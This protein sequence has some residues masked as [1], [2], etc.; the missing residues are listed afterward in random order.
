M[1]CVT[2]KK[3]GSKGSVFII[4]FTWH[5]GRGKTIGTDNKSVVAKIWVCGEDLTVKGHE[6]TWEWKNYSISWFHGKGED[7]ESV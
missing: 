6:E 2:W 4:S 5:S 3:S 7:I 1:H